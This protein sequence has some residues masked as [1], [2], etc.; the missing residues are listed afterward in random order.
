MKHVLC[1]GEALVDLIVDDGPDASATLLY[2]A[3]P[4][5]APANVAVAVAR[6]GGGARFLGKIATD[7]M[8]QMVFRALVDNRVDVRYVRRTGSATT[9]VALVSVDANQGRRFTFCRA[10]AADTQL[11]ASDLSHQ[12]W[13]DVGIAYTGSVLLATE[14]SR[15]A[16]FAA[17]D[18]TRSAGCVMAF[19][20]NVRAHLWT[21]SGDEMRTILWDAIARADILKVSD[22]ETRYLAD[23]PKDP[24]DWRS[25]ADRALT[26]GTGLVIVTRGALGSVLMTARHSVEL[27]VH[28]VRI[29]DST[30]AGDAY[31]GAVIY[32][33]LQHGWDTSC[34]VRDLAVDELREIGNLATKAAAFSCTRPGG[35]LSLPRPSDLTF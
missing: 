17:M 22:E 33:L 12:A 15:S 6:L 2:R 24:S 26:L 30:G 13:G 25:V 10:D 21:S 11:T 27:P 16:L 32:Q 3:H 28:P 29:V 7:A 35:L 4:G 20:A 18:H 23:G 34:Q 8:G 31:M 14:P 1:I 19:D 9:T 5:G